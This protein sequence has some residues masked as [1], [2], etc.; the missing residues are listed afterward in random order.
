MTKLRET[1]K[2]LDQSTKRHENEVLRKKRLAF[3]GISLDNVILHKGEGQ[4]GSKGSQT[5]SQESD[6]GECRI[7]YIAIYFFFFSYF[8]LNSMTC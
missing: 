3:V 6:N 2:T 7:F 5:S 4:H 1:V 8:L